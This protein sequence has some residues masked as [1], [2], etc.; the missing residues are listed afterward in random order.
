LHIIGQAT[1]R[2]PHALKLYT[3]KRNFI[4]NE[5]RKENPPTMR[6]ASREM[7]AR[8]FAQARIRSV[9]ATYNCIGM[10]F[11]A[12]RTWI[13]PDQL[14]TIFRDDG[15]FVVARRCD[16]MPGDLVVY[17]HQPEG[18]I[19]HIAMVLRVHVSIEADGRR[20]IE[21]FSQW[22]ADAECIHKEDRVPVL[23]G[24]HRQYYTER[25]MP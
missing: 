9:S 21:C 16:V 8:Q 22:G 11:G 3:K 24:P 20:E 5:Q 23:F 13:D 17:R 14:P 12:R 7:I 6:A 4:Q 10:V 15:Y 25:S 2:D 19:Q 1:E 18:D